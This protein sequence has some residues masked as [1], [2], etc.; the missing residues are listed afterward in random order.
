MSALHEQGFS[1]PRPVDHNR[2]I[3]LMSRVDGF[4]MAQMKA[5]SLLGAEQVFSVC[6][7]MLRRLA[8]IGLIHCDF[9]EFNLLIGDDGHITMIDFP[10]VDDLMLAFRIC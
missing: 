5:G 4:P 8:E 7:I 6:V 10:Q 3:V 1:T 2:H 9:N